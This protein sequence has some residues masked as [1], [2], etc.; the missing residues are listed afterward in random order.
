[1]P[2]AFALRTFTM[3]WVI[4]IFQRWRN[5]ACA[6]LD[7]ES[8]DIYWRLEGNNPHV[9]SEGA[10]VIAKVGANV[11]GWCVGDRAGVKPV[12]DTCG[13]CE[14]CLGDKEVYCSNAIWTGLQKV[15][16]PERV[17]CYVRITNE[18]TARDVSAV[19]RIASPIHNAHSGRCQRLHSR[20]SNVLG[21]NCLPI[22]H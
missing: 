16:R 22:P 20:S 1:M 3:L 14:L 15:R 9:C 7:S 6:P 17:C 10:G 12:W 4:W 11:T 13:S 2:L 21:V 19:H 5:L 8:S 18:K